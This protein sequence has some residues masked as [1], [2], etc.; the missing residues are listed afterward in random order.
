MKELVAKAFEAGVRESIKLLRKPPVTPD[1][2]AKAAERV[3]K[4]V[5]KAR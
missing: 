2:L 5:A 1:R 3:M 4:A